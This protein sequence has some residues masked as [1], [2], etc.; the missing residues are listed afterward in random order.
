CTPSATSALTVRTRR[1]RFS[2]EL[3]GRHDLLPRHIRKRVD[4]HIDRI[5]RLQ[6]VEEVFQRY[7]GSGKYRFARENLRIGLD[8]FVPRRHQAYFTRV[9]ALHNFSRASIA[10]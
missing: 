10:V 8:D 4:E 2:C 7:P 5:A 9:S 6:V 1:Y 3:Q